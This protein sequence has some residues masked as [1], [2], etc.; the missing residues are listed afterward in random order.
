MGVKVSVQQGENTE[1]V[2]AV[3]G[4]LDIFI[5]RNFS[6]WKRFDLFFRMTEM[7]QT[8]KK[9][10]KIMHG[11]SNDV[12]RRRREEK[13][14]EKSRPLYSDD[15]TK[16]KI[17]LLDMLLESEDNVTLSNED[18]REEI[19]TFMFEG[20]DTTTSGIAFAMLALAD[21]PEVQ[22]KV[23]E[24]VISIVGDE[25]N[26]TMQHMQETKYL[27]MTLKEVQRLYPSVPIFERRLEE[28]WQI[29]LALK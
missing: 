4:F 3:R 1:Y 17:A 20:H 29:G 15:G 12:I 16:R 27:E 2:E 9:Y 25:Q 14:K 8:F 22:E 13:S 19:D 21:N 28:D 10:L 24:E 7:Y 26:V 6:T 5:T 18:I 11:F 23:Y